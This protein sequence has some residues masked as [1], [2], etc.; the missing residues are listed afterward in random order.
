MAA[1]DDE[2]KAPPA[3]GGS[4][5][6][7]MD[8]LGSDPDHDLDDF[9][10]ALG[11]DEDDSDEPMLDEVGGE[12]SFDFDPG[13]VDGSFAAG[14]IE[15]E[16]GAK[17]RRW[18]LVAAILLLLAGGGGAATYLFMGEEPISGVNAAGDRAW[19]LIEE[20]VVRRVIASAA[21]IQSD[22]CARNP[23]ACSP[24]P[25]TSESGTETA[26]LL[27]PEGVAGGLAD[28]VAAGEQLLSEMDKEMAARQVEIEQERARL[29]SMQADEEQ[30]ARE[31]LQRMEAELVAQRAEA[32]QR[33]ARLEALRQRQ[34]EQMD[35]EL[36][37]IQDTGLPKPVLKDPPFPS[38]SRD[39]QG[40]SKPPPYYGMLARIE[41][42]RPLP[43]APQ[44]GL[45]QRTIQDLL[46]PVIADDGR[47]PWTEYARPFDHPSNPV[48]SIIIT[49]LGLREE[50]SDAAV[51][52]L[53]P[54]VTLAFSPY[55]ER[56]NTQVR[57]ARENGHEVLLGLPLE[58][59]D[60]PH[61]DPGELGLITKRPLDDNM[62]ALE[63]IMARATGYV[64]FVERG[65]T[66]FARS[67]QHMAPVLQEIKD[68][69]LAYVDHG[70]TKLFSDDGAPDIPHI[71]IDV[72]IDE[73]RFQEAI[74]AR[75][76]YLKEL[77]KYQGVAV[78]VMDASPL[79][80]SRV[81]AFLDTLE[82][83][84]GDGI[85]VKLAPVTTAIRRGK[86]LSS[87]LADASGASNTHVQ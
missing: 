48:I 81:L 4:A 60:F 15:G 52:S 62:G 16:E 28:T 43:Q 46:L 78:G 21:P 2:D 39:D 72:V 13:D 56:L 27:P 77:A 51:A 66:T 69:G 24:A 23:E 40:Q 76:T 41:G 25:E 7:R 8:A 61:E 6:D 67:N 54:D 12:S 86:T 22:F 14:D 3:T 9:L 34:R 19:R 20:E 47:K 87:P 58:D 55:A 49:N 33:K 84:D 63:R 26:A 82:T 68:R 29:A 37:A 53:P 18:P 74:D 85:I 17:K 50:P 44:P 5:L 30:K 32:A 10:S 1:K 38:I 73:R 45:Q 65:G 71:S 36:R 80:F 70:R 31:E 59:A 64:G 83:D 75:L 35:A 57:N 79:G 42:V 11:D